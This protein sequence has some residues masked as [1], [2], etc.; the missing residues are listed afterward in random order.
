MPWAVAH[1][2]AG[3]DPASFTLIWASA[4]ML[5]QTAEAAADFPYDKESFDRFTQD[6]R[7][8]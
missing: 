7:A 4:E 3:M 8:L 2:G 5:E 6:A 1:T